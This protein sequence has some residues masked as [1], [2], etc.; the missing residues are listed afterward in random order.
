M[1]KNS[2]KDLVMLV[3]IYMYHLHYYDV[4]N[5]VYDTY[6]YV[7]NNKIIISKYY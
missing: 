4:I 6:I 2:L 5:N 3:H 1:N 7:L